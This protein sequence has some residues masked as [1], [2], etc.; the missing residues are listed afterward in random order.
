MGSRHARARSLQKYA[1]AH[2]ILREAEQ[3]AYIAESERGYLESYLGTDDQIAGTGEFNQPAGV[4]DYSS[5][6]QLDWSSVRDQQT[7]D[8]YIQDGGGSRYSLSSFPGTEGGIGGGRSGSSQMI[9]PKPDKYY[10]RRLEDANSLLEESEQAFRDGDKA[11]ADDLKKQAQDLIDDARHSDSFNLHQDAEKAAKGALSNPMAR[12][13]GKAVNRALKLTDRGSA[14]FSATRANITDKPIEAIQFGLE[15][16]ERAI[17]A[18]QRTI[19]SQ[20]K[21]L[22]AAS[23]NTRDPVK[24]AALTARARDQAMF[25]RAQARTQAASAIS[26]IVGDANVFMEKFS[27]AYA[28]DSVRLAREW[29][30]GTPGVRDAFQEKMGQFASAQAALFA[31]E[32]AESWAAYQQF[33][34]MSAERRANNAGLAFSVAGT[35]V[36]A[37]GGPFLA[38]LGNTAG[39]AAGQ[40]LFG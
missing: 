21:M 31:N 6:Y 1:S 3:N 20:N 35:V 39:K 26:T 23:G 15:N 13:V 40:T 10:E 22:T 4:S 34:Q 11:R 14:E 28:Q 19:E 16:A 9:Q 37:F 30:N 38:A 5:R 7:A 27:S 25:Q 36:G 8:S 29:V 12:I 24:Q 33:V 17:V 32:G 18:E 2:E